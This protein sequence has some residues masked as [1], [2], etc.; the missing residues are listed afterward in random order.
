[1]SEA[2]LRIPHDVESQTAPVQSMRGRAFAPARDLPCTLCPAERA[3]QFVSRA[4][5]ERSGRPGLSRPCAK[6]SKSIL[7]RV[8]AS[9]CSPAL[10]RHRL[11]R[12][13]ELPN[14]SPDESRT[15]GNQRL[16]AAAGVVVGGGLLVL[17]AT[18]LRHEFLA[19]DLHDLR[20]HLLSIPRPKL[21]AALGLT[22]LGYL[23]LTGYDAL[24][25]RSVGR[26][27][28][29]WRIGFYSFVAFVFSHNVGLSVFGGSAVRFRILSSWGVDA[30]DIARV[31]AFTTLTFWIGFFTLGGVLHCAWPLPVALR[32]YPFEST[33]P[34][35]VGLLG[36]T[37]AYGLFVA[38]RRNP[39]VVHGFRI[40]PPTAGMTAAQLAVSNVDWLLAAG[41][42]Y[43][44]LPDAPGLSFPMLA[45]AYLISQVIGL[46]SHVP[47]G[48]GVFE[49]AM[50][51]LL[52]RWLPS[53]QILA[54]VL[55]YRMI[56]YL[57]PLAVAALLFVLYEVGQRR[58]TL[59][60]TG[61]W[62]KTGMSAFVPRFF[63]VTIFLSG[64]MLLFSGATP[65]LPDRLH[66]LRRSLPLPLIELSKLMGSV[67]GVALLLLANALRQRIDAAYPGTLALLFGGA[68]ASLVKGLDWEEASILAAMALLLVPCRRFF[69]RRSSLL[70]QPL[71]GGWWLAVGVT[72]AGVL[73]TLDLAFRQVPYSNDLWW[74]FDH[75]AT[76]PR[77][78]RATLAGGI[79]LL[80]IG[81]SRLLRPAPPRPVLPT[82]SELDRAQAI[83]ARSPRTTGFLALLGDK[84]LLFH[85][86]GQAFLMYGISGRTWVAMGDPVGDPRRQ[87]ELAWRFLELADRHGAR[88]T[89]Y[90]VT[91]QTLPIYLE[92]G[93]DLYKLGEE[94]HVRLADFS[95]EGSARKGLR[96][97][98]NRLTREGCRF[99]ILPADRVAGVLDELEAISND[100]LSSKR[101]R[102]KR[103]S[104][105]FFDRAYLERL[106]VALVRQSGR[107]VAFANVWPSDV[108][109]DLSID[110][111]RF[112]ASAPAGVMEYLFTQ[113]MSWGHAEGYESFSLGMSPLS[114]FEHH[115]LAPLWNRVGA[116]LFQHGEHFYNFQGLRDFK[117]KFDP[118]WE[119][120]YLAAPG[121]ITTPLVL[122]QIATLVSGGVL[123]LVRR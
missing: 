82:V 59:V 117:E 15:A 48:F 114:G 102:E 85:E 93:L 69:Y 80:A 26:R 61:A 5:C 37:I 123:G 38:L 68:A 70:S 14:D 109:G 16:V 56:Y 71:S 113:M 13:P 96:N 88:T 74:Q 28:S 77:A 81:A 47:G 35:G 39:F 43:V 116:M 6:V 21:F 51:M 11:D 9:C 104:L 89:F 31:I 64:V 112:G 32:G 72:I 40:G 66:W 75:T 3:A 53:D 65:E 92:L 44:I 18:I 108:K 103:F 27:L 57:V 1:M 118:V 36:V 58:A 19:H 22:S 17:A 95:L 33:R 86:D 79:V 46:I 8:A 73:A 2:D 115:R 60:R 50:V 119:P 101:V 110:L 107:I 106:P 29:Y 52:R 78:F 105:G 94:G 4:R 10:E 23:V 30:D 7:C 121:G 55:A 120:R 90:E 42:L 20:A 100:W 87:E 111:M 24:A 83:A 91:D 25:L 54:S 67:I 12:S 62:M 97:T 34:I 63:A 84:E 122:S 76:M 49:T 45:G 99:E 41:V 98:Q